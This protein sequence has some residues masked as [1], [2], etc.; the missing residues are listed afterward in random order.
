MRVDD[1]PE[2]YAV[3]IPGAGVF[4]F[5]S[6]EG[7]VEL[8]TAVAVVSDLRPDWPY[9]YHILR[10]DRAVLGSQ[11]SFRTMPRDQDPRGV[12]FA[13]V[14]CNS[15]TELG[16]WPDLR[17]YVFTGVPPS[18]GHSIRAERPYFL[19]MVGDQVYMD[20]KIKSEEFGEN[21]W[22]EYFSSSPRERR[23]AIAQWYQESWGRK[24][25]RDVMAS[26]PTYMMWD[27]HEIR[28]GWGS[29][30]HDSP[31]IAA[32]YPD[33]A[34][35]H[36]TY[37]A[38]FEDFRTVY[39]HFQRSHG[40][41][42]ESVPVPGERR[43]MP[44]VFR[45]GRVLVLMIDSRGDRDV[46]RDEAD[47]P[48]LGRDQWAFIHEVLENVP[49][50]VDHLVITTAAPIAHY[51]KGGSAQHRVVGYPAETT[52][53]VS[54][55]RKGSYIAGDGQPWSP[56]GGPPP[57]NVRMPPIK[58]V[59]RVVTDVRDQWPHH[60]TRREQ[61]ELIRAASR[62]QFTNRLSG[63]ARDLV[64]VAGD[65]HFGGDYRIKVRRPTDSRGLKSTCQCFFSSGIGKRIS[66]DNLELTKGGSSVKH[67]FRTRGQFQVARGIVSRMKSTEWRMN[68]GIVQT[69]RSDDTAK[70][71]RRRRHRPHSNIR[72]SLQST[73]PY[74]TRRSVARKQKRN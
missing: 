67:R 37:N 12:S 13:T 30:A 60:Y 34:H 10:R 65:V 2:A 22:E 51:S 20:N 42:L 71:P 33:N 14:S 64:F 11:G 23:A 50:D 7:E 54:A 55:F 69:G 36:T 47:K 26:I 41:T 74:S 68:F 16:C 4:P 31:T 59:S 18:G 32:R 6:T 28:N 27:D 48:A 40:P 52:Y 29:L 58:K 39:W 57:R 56:G 38:V 72:T 70:W 17:D 9:L 15:N 8:G 62:A 66:D 21:A 5:M 46:F 3:R 25:V 19:L 53:D 61:E 44:V 73:Q 24:V 1:D 43:A 49:A 63:R 35:L 45:I